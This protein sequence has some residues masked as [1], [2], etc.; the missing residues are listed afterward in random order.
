MTQPESA[1]VELEGNAKKVIE[2]KFTP[3]KVKPKRKYRKGSKYSP[4]LDAF[5]EGTD[6]LSQVS[7][8]GVSAN[9]LRTQLNKR[10]EAE[11]TKYSKISV[12]VVNN[13]LYLEKK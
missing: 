5:K 2:F 4:I 13:K 10:I 7:I 1:E 9:Y 8:A 3:V 6:K 11:P 12:S